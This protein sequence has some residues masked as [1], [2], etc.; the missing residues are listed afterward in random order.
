MTR[1]AAFADAWGVQPVDIGVGG[2]IP[3][4][5]ALPRSSRRRPSSSPASRTRTREPTW[6]QRVVAP[7]EFEKVCVAEAVLLARLGGVAAG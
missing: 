4:V 2:S 6:R 7:G 1:R 3:F 5:A